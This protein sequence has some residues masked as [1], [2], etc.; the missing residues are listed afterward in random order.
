MTMS[1]K[2]T[3]SSR[4]ITFLIMFCCFQKAIG[5]DISIPKDTTKKATAT[6]QLLES[7][8]TNTTNISPSPDPAGLARYAENEV[9]LVNGLVPITIP[10]CTIESGNLKQPVFLGFHTAGPKVNDIASSSGLGWSLFSGGVITRNMIGRPD[11]YNNSYLDTTFP[12][13]GD[14]TAQNNDFLCFLGRLA[15][16]EGSTMDGS[17]DGFF[18]NYSGNSGKFQIA[19]RDRNQNAIN[20]VFVSVPYK[21]IKID[22]NQPTNSQDINRFT[23]TDTDGTKY[24]FGQVDGSPNNYIE[25]TQVGNLNYISSWYLNKIES[26]IADDVIDF[27]YTN[28][29]G[30][31][32]KTIFQLVMNEWTCCV[33]V[34]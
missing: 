1:T 9:D 24:Y 18:Y 25:R 7:Q 21:P 22:Y 34:V 15:S 20:A 31:K 30:L 14:E 23:I 16:Y 29:V 28:S 13:V 19:R 8:A 3:C 10:L 17:P 32:R 11:E 2:M 4:F 26:A 33:F 12:T 27:T 5:Q 6:V